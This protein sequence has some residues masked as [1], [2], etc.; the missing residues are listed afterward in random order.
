M[1]Q[2]I[3]EFNE[4][5][6]K[7]ERLDTVE[8]DDE[9]MEQSKTKKQQRRDSNCSEEERKETKSQYTMLTA[10]SKKSIKT[11]VPTSKKDRKSNNFKSPIVNAKRPQH[12]ESESEEESEYTSDEHTHPA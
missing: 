7:P 6:S 4:D 5:N 9:T 3:A 1:K 12:S 2:Q 8:A 10:K 11:A